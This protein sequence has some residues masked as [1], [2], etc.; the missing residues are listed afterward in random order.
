MEVGAGLIRP[1][2]PLSSRDGDHHR[3][4]ANDVESATQILG[5]RSQTKFGSNLSNP[6]VRDAP[7]L[8]Y[9]LMAPNGCSAVS[10]RRSM[11]SGD[12]H[13]RA[14]IRSGAAPFFRHETLRGERGAQQ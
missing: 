1:V 4:D 11:I 7:G 5:E 8:I 12:S 13:I 10:R 2:G 14:S 6:R 9:C 3:S